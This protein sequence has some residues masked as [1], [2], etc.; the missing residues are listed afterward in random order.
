MS[1]EIPIPKWGPRL[2]RLYS[3]DVHRQEKLHA[4]QLMPGTTSWED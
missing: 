3:A 2:A 1:D 4:N